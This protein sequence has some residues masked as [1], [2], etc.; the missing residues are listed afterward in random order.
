MF[1]GIIECL[2]DIKSIKSNEENLTFEIA[3]PLGK[4]L[5]VDQSFAHNGVCLTV[6]G[7]FEETYT[8]TAIAETIRKTNVGFWKVGDKVNQERAMM[9]GARMDGHM[10]QGHVDTTAVCQSVKYENGSWE[11]VFMYEPSQPEFI[12]VP[13]GSI[14]VDGVSL[15][16]V[17]SEKGLFSVHIIPYTY[18]HTIFHT[19]QPGTVVN[20]EFDILGKYFT[21]WM[22]NYQTR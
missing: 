13:K 12:T 7:L 2:G 6:D 16:V 4:E 1:T 15:T 9:L 21:R 19:Y 17:K 10:V 22:E 5:K 11:Y 14:C 18:E 8:V 3:S 20:I